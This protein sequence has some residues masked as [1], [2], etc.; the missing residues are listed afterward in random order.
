MKDFF[1][2]LRR[3]ILELVKSDQ[4]QKAGCLR[5]FDLKIFIIFFVS[6]FFQIFSFERPIRENIKKSI[7]IIKGQFFPC[8]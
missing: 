6:I 3:P 8:T 2:N 1:E 7:K 5:N 4:K